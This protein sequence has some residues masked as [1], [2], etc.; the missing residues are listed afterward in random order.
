MD[1]FIHQTVINLITFLGSMHHNWPL[2]TIALAAYLPR[3]GQRGN[4]FRRNSRLS[5]ASLK[6]HPSRSCR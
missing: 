3:D 1:S 2:S 4:K 6:D 5:Y